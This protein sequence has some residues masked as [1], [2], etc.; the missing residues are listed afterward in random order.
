MAFFYAE[1]MYNSLI[2]KKETKKVD[3]NK[4]LKLPKRII[5]YLKIELKETL[6]E[7]KKLEKMLSN[8]KTKNYDN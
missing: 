3:P 6:A 8:N 7:A 5:E 2:P 4:T 1:S